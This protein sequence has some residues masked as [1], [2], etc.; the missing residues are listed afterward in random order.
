MR[1]SKPKLS[2]K[3][4]TL[5]S[6]AFCQPEPTSAEWSITLRIWPTAFLYGCGDFQS[7]CVDFVFLIMW[8]SPFVKLE[9]T[10]RICGHFECGKSVAQR[11]FFV[12]A[13]SSFQ[14]CKSYHPFRATSW[15]RVALDGKHSIVFLSLILSHPC[16]AHIFPSRSATVAANGESAVAG[17]VHDGAGSGVPRLDSA[18]TFSQMGERLTK[19][20]HG[21]LS[22][23]LAKF[24]FRKFPYSQEW[25]N[26]LKHT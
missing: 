22:N 6:I 4:V 5:L 26:L 16:P 11:N 19:S 20:T 12:A 1:I 24:S 23:N 7:V 21:A 15:Y 3:S 9:I 18:C 25:M 17:C 14:Q 13:L 10:S 2:A 8:S